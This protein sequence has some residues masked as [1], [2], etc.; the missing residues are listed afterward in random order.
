MGK[1]SRCS[2]VENTRQESTSVF[3]TRNIAQWGSVHLKDACFLRRVF[4]TPGALV[5]FVLVLCGCNPQDASNLKTDAGK[6]VKTTT[7]AAGNAKVAGN[8]NLILASWKGI[9]MD[10]FRVEAKDSTV[11]LVGT[12]PT[13]KEKAEVER[14]C[15]Q[16]RGVD[17]V[18]N[19]LKVEAGK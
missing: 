13:A 15:K 1:L 14:V 6:L 9:H 17:K 11:T 2:G 12:V 8:V 18:I 19:N 16:I 3:Q 4:S 10:R 5:I 7:E